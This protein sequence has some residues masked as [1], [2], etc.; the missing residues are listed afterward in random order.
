MKKTVIITIRFS[1]TYFQPQQQIKNRKLSQKKQSGK[2]ADGR[3]ENR[4][5]TLGSSWVIMIINFRQ[6]K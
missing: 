4:H 2:K 6:I 5:E 1:Q 3:R